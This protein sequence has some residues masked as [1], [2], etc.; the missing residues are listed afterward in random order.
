MF[1]Y[2]L[3]FEKKNKE[4]INYLNNKLI[5]NFIVYNYNFVNKKDFFM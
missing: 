5:N 1:I 3:I 4:N 2:L